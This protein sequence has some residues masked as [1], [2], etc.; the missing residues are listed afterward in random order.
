MTNRGGRYNA[1]NK[2]PER[3]GLIAQPTSRIVKYVNHIAEVNDDGALSSSEGPADSRDQV[4]D[5]TGHIPDGL[6]RWIGPCWRAI[7]PVKTMVASARR[8]WTGKTSMSKI[9][10]AGY[11]RPEHDSRRPI[12][13]PPS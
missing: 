13:K 3:P 12:N 5:H 9:Q 6:S 4:I 10:E 2:L 11:G 1:S 8:F 7:K